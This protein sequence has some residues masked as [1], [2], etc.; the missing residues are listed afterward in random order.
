M[1]VVREAGIPASDESLVE[2]VDSALKALERNVGLFDYRWL[3]AC[4]VFPTL[5]LP[6]TL[7]L[8]AALRRA[9]GEAPPSEEDVLTL[10]SLPWFRQGWMPNAWRVAL[11]SK[12]SARDR[13]TVRAALADLMY[14]MVDANDADARGRV[15]VARV[16]QAP[17]NFVQDWAE[18]RE[19]L[20]SIISQRDLALNAVMAPAQSSRRNLLTLGIGAALGT[21]G[22]IGGFWGRT[23]LAP[24]VRAAI[25]DQ[26]FTKLAAL[27]STGSLAALVH[28]DGR[29][30]LGN[31]D[32]RP[33]QIWSMASSGLA[34]A[35]GFN[36]D[37]L[38]L[39]TSDSTYDWCPSCS[40]GNGQ[41]AST[42]TYDRIAAAKVSSD[43]GAIAYLTTVA[44]GGLLLGMRSGHGPIITETV[45]APVDNAE[46]LLAI[47][48]T[49]RF[50]ITMVG[51]EILVF[52]PARGTAVKKIAVNL[53][54]HPTLLAVGESQGIGRAYEIAFAEANGMVAAGSMPGSLVGF[55][56]GIGPLDFLAVTSSPG[57]IAPLVIAGAQGG[58]IAVQA[59]DRVILDGHTGAIR[60]A[61]FSDDFTILASGSDDGTARLWQLADGANMVLP[62]GSPV[63][64]VVFTIGNQ[65]LV[66]LSA[67]GVVRRWQIEGFAKPR[68]KGG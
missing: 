65:Q 45:P 10:A 64:Q 47:S 44:S 46:P 48:P 63:L 31:T 11:L 30:T 9:D 16:K 29:V 66:T 17:R 2:D 32:G 3:T 1:E 54:A 36:G 35:L 62:T 34:L 19:G 4:A 27:N 55:N 67:D 68:G 50:V 61:C 18:W 12:Q 37:S 38:I 40:N 56:P 26:K 24:V 13:A 6:V 57:V 41:P 43:G 8:G 5:R 53:T 42:S 15:T 49:G 14:A 33:G 58:R 25:L 52:E 39:I 28:T 51:N 7:H 59:P 21:A 23:Y 22:L 60:A 20:P